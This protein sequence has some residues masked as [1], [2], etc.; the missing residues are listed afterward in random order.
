[1]EHLPFEFD[2]FESDGLQVIFK[3]VKFKRAFGEF[4]LA[5]V[6]DSVELD[7]HAGNLTA[8][9]ANDMPDVVEHFHLMSGV[10]GV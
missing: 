10:F 3:G 5:S 4:E 9:D 8:Y 7:L 2:D 6:W 1:M